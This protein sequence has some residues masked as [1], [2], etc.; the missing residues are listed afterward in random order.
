MIG[1]IGVVIFR[2]PTQKLVDPTPEPAIGFLFSDIIPPKRG[3]IRKSGVERL[4]LDIA[5]DVRFLEFYGRIL[6]ND[7]VLVKERLSFG[8]KTP[9]GTRCEQGGQDKEEYA[10]NEF[11]PHVVV[12]CC[13]SNKIRL[14]L[15]Q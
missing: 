4:L 11:C 5:G 8:D 14:L 6:D 12:F 1:G 9:D 3:A 13:K 10:M 2:L 7:L 15:Q